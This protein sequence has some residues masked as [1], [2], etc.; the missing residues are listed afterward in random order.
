MSLA[1]PVLAGADGD[2]KTEVS[3]VINDPFTT[4]EPVSDTPPPS[5]QAEDAADG[6]KDKDDNLDDN[7]NGKGNDDKDQKEPVVDEPVVDEPVVDEPVVDEPAVDEP[8]VDEPA[9]EDPAF[10][11]PAPEDAAPDVPAV[12]APTDETAD[13][14]K[15]KDDN[16][17]DNDN[18]IG[19]DDKESTTEIPQ[20]EEPVGQ[21]PAIEAEPVAA[22]PDFPITRPVPVSSTLIRIVAKP[23]PATD[24]TSTVSQPVPTIEQVAATT[25]AADGPTAAPALSADIDP[26]PT[27]QAAPSV[28][29]NAGADVEEITNP[30]LM[31]PEGFS[32]PAEGPELS[33]TPVTGVQSL[34][35]QI[36]DV[37][38]DA[39]KALAV[40]AVSLGGVAM[41][42]WALKPTGILRIL[43]L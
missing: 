16:L 2:D 31:L 32:A 22:A 43:G 7:D 5:D 14:V 26:T 1:G 19:N 3:I 37:A 40:P 10:E 4:E 12:D 29:T 34:G 17:D 20:V 13:G 42:G 39:A 23:T 30:R 9:E 24:E 15:D 38:A 35:S 28:T 41:L 33:L 21:A 11:E 36:T 18:G 27:A 25:S 8:V 6:V